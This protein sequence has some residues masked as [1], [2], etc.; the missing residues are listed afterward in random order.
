MSFEVQTAEGSPQLAAAPPDPELG[1]ASSW[2]GWSGAGSAPQSSEGLTPC[3]VP[4]GEEDLAGHKAGL[5]TL[6]SSLVGSSERPR[7]DGHLGD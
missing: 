2:R 6:S 1:L 4:R 7:Q 5:T 3:P